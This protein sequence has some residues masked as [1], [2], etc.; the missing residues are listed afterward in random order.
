MFRVL[1][2]GSVPVP[3]WKYKIRPHSTLSTARIGT[4]YWVF[5]SSCFIL[6]TERTDARAFNVNILYWHRVRSF[7]LFESQQPILF[8]SHLTGRR[9]GNNSVTMRYYYYVVV[10]VTGNFSFK[11]FRRAQRA[12]PCTN[13]TCSTG[14]RRRRIDTHRRMRKQPPPNSHAWRG[15]FEVSDSELPVFCR[16]SPKT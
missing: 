13:W 11:H 7:V 3:K 4:T 2:L 16:Q 9:R 1:L 8:R 6:K 5:K 12:S 14:R 10:D 15:A